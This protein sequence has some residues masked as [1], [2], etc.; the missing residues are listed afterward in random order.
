MRIEPSQARL[1]AS[2]IARIGISF[3]ALPPQDP[4]QLASG[5]TEVISPYLQKVVQVEVKG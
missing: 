2:I 3:I 5:L 1:A 4:D